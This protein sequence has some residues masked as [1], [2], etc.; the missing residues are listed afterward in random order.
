MK[1]KSF[2]KELPSGY[3]QVIY[4]NAKEFKLG[5]ILNLVAFA[6]IAVVMV[7][8]FGVFYLLGG[9]PTAFSLNPLMTLALSFAAFFAYIILH[10]LT[11]GAVYKLM[12][13]EKLTF[14]MSWSCAF[15][16]V[17][18]IY[19]YRKTIGRSVAAPLILFSVILIPLTVILY[20]VHPMLYFVSALLFGYHLGGCSGDIYVLILLAK[21]KDKRLLVR[22]TGPEQFFYLPDESTED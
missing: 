3:R 11:H 10:E 12:T 6:V 21:Y 2:E 14:G 4:L 19:T 5:V 1:E 9:A 8:A 18:N 22:D 16:G 17:P 13:G 7:I 20:F 15:C